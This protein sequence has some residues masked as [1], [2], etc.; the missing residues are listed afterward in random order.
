M[1]SFAEEPGEILRIE[2]PVYGGDGLAHDAAGQVVFVPFTLPGELVRVQASE[3]ATGGGKDSKRIYELSEWSEPSPERVE[4][5]CVHFG[6]CGGCQYQMASEPAQLAMKGAILQE[7]LAQA[8]VEALPALQSW[9]SPES[10]GYRNRVR[11]RVR[12]VEGELRL[13]YSL[14]GT[15]DFLP[16]TMCPIAAPLLWRGVEAVLASAAGS[17]ELARWL[18]SAAEIEFFCDGEQTRLQITLFCPGK[19]PQ[20]QSSFGKAMDAVRTLCPEL[21]GAGAVRV[22]ARS[23]R[24]LE[25]LATSG[26]AGLSY[27]VGDETYWISRGGFFQVN[28]FLLPTLVKLVCGE[29]SGVQAWDLFAGVGLFSRVLARQFQ[30]VTAVEAN[31]TANA[32]LRRALAKLGPQHRAVEA[33]TL[34]FLRGAAVERERPELIVLDPPRA[35]AGQEV[36]ELLIR[37]APVEIVYLSCDPTTLARDLAVLTRSAYGITALHL[38]DL[39]PQTYHLETLVVLRRVDVSRNVP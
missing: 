27:P 29:R 38:I 8:G 5:R 32:D 20:S 18:E 23:G 9:P 1:T 28:R 7:T 4:P 6:V 16:V 33:T 22:E 15:N 3:A 34:D 11:L 13:G 25:V 35:G 31:P 39:F 37:L 36:C 10:Y 24:L 19:I 14:R 2:T 26:T 21:S 30:S 17:A 12:R